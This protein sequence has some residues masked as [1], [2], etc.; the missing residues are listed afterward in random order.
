MGLLKSSR[1]C[2]RDKVETTQLKLVVSDRIIV[3]VFTGEIFTT[4]LQLIL[5]EFSISS[6][7]E[8][9]LLRP[10]QLSSDL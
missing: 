7:N 10:P 5:S 3:F 6:V 1:T 2:S 4:T 8:I 9:Q